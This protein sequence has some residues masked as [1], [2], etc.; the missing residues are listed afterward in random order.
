MARIAAWRGFEVMTRRTRTSSVCNNSEDPVFGARTPLPSMLPQISSSSELVP[1]PPAVPF[2]VGVI[3][4]PAPE[5][6]APLPPT[7]VAKSVG[8]VST[9]PDGDPF[10]AR[11]LRSSRR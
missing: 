5:D 11:P 1:V 3:T 4:P 8:P 2:I 9:K 7:S 10:V 6:L